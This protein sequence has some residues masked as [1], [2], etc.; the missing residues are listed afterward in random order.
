MAEL[1][2]VASMPLERWNG[3]LFQSCPRP[4]VAA[5]ISLS[6]LCSPSKQYPAFYLAAMAPEPIVINEAIESAKLRLQNGTLQSRDQVIA[7]SEDA[8]NKDLE[9][10]YKSTLLREKDARLRRFNHALPGLGNIT[11]SL[12]GP[13]VKLATADSKAVLFFLVFDKGVFDY[14]LG[15]G[16]SATPQKQ[17][18]DG[19]SICFRTSFRFTELAS[20]PSKIREQIDP[21]VIKDG[22]YTVSQ[23]LLTFSAAAVAK[24]DWKNSICPGIQDNPNM[25]YTS[26]NMF[27]EFMK[28]YMDFMS[29]GPYSVLG[30]AIKLDSDITSPDLK[31]L[32]P[33]FPVTSLACQT[34]EYKACLPEFATHPSRSSLDQFLYLGMTE[35]RDFPKIPY[36]STSSVNWCYSGLPASLCISKR[37]LWERFFAVKL[38]VLNDRCVTLANDL[39]WWVEDAKNSKANNNDWN[40]DSNNKPANFDWVVGV[41]RLTY[42]FV[43]KKYTG[44]NWDGWRHEIDA[45]VT[46]TMKWTPGTEKASMSVDIWVRHKH[47]TQGH[48]GGSDSITTTSSSIKW[49]TDLSL[50]ASDHDAGL[51]VTITNGEVKL[52]TKYE[53]TQ[54]PFDWAGT[55]E[56]NQKEAE[57]SMQSHVDLSAIGSELGQALSGSSKFVFPGGGVFALKSPAF[58]NTGDLLVEL[59]YTSKPINIDDDFTLQILAKDK[60]FNLHYL[61]IAKDGEGSPAQFVADEK[62]ATMFTLDDGN[63]CEQLSDGKR[64]RKATIPENGTDQTLIFASPSAAKEPADKKLEFST[65]GSAFAYSLDMQDW[66]NNLRV[67]DKG[68]V[69]I[70][71]TLDPTTT[72]ALQAIY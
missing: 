20:V 10:R 46:N 2:I 11:A 72:Y 44:S 25:K 6:S 49:N 51:V 28:T 7:I 69:E 1:S 53:T 29:T 56:R 40:I 8:I 33:S 43:G 23:L 35:T 70:M 16:P 32:G 31:P 13:R 27:E 66:F 50:A 26:M 67:N 65:T 21:R 61:K 34:Q 18:I 39:F 54:D 24:I 17:T 19:W 30:Y 15:H 4:S 57:S 38:R 12:T 22:T 63:L 62:Q 68:L 59:R 14:W 47:W 36:D 48:R 41:D 37:V 5:L 55:R 9:A 58:N 52:D 71:F 64:G 3:Q 60:D 45:K 42:A